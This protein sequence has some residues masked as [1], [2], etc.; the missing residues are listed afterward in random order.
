MKMSVCKRFEAA[1]LMDA[2]S[3]LVQILEHLEET[4]SDLACT[5]REG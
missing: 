3:V 2:A 4:A 1:E 5:A